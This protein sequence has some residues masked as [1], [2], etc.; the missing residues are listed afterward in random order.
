MRRRNRRNHYRVLHVQPEAPHEVI[1]AA[2]RVLMGTLRGHPD[3][4]GDPEQAALYNDAWAV[5]GDP[6]RRAAY[7]KELAGRVR[8]QRRTA[9]AGPPGAAEAAPTAGRAAPKSP[10]ASVP[11]PAERQED[12]PRPAHPWRRV[13]L[14]PMCQTPLPFRLA[15]DTSCAGCGGPLAPAPSSDSTG[16]ELFGRRSAPRMPREDALTVQ[17]VRGGASLPAQWRDV[18]MTGLSFLAPVEL[19]PG[20]VLRIRD[21]TLDALAEVVSCHG[22]ASRKL[23]HA[24]LLTVRF[25]KTQG[26]FV[27]AKV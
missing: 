14:C 23:V 2:Y 1:K 18:S 4:G 25:L 21:G 15:S 22:H 3:L 24:R 8:G 7:D 27:S 5:L 19:L 12:A 9:Q 11:E 17:L 16:R 26:Q 10:T 6:A 20:R 13:G